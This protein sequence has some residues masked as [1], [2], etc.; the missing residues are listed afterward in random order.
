MKRVWQTPAK[1]LTGFFVAAMYAMPQATISARPG[2]INYI[3]GQTY[4]D[5]Q[6]LSQ[7]GLSK[8]TALYSNQT[9][10]TEK[11][12]A[13][14]LL[15]PGVFLRI[16]ENSEIRMVSPSLTNTQ[17]EVTKGEAIIEVNQLF[18]DSDVQIIEHGSSIT[19]QKPGVYRFM[20]DVPP[21]VSVLDGKAQVFLGEQKVDL[22]KGRQVI[23]ADNLTPQKFDTKKQKQDELY[24]WSD[25]RSEYNAGASYASAKT[26]SQS[27]GFGASSLWGGGAYG[28]GNSFYTPGWFW[29][30]GWNSWAWLP[31]A[32]YA[33]SPF[34]WGFY[35]PGYVLY[36]PVIYRPVRGG[37][38]IPVPYHPGRPVSN[39]PGG[40]IS[41]VPGGV[42]GAI[43]PTAITRNVPANSFRNGAVGPVTRSAPSPAFR[44]APGGMPRSASPG[45]V[46]S[47]G[48]G[49]SMGRGGAAGPSRR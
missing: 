29:N 33:Y 37:G 5:G 10:S 28:Y 20:A 13:E 36:A 9:L 41:T 16:G 7:K 14:V 34:G 21:S 40:P 27:N 30:S 23:L 31:G 19:L 12:K 6:V 26:V 3:E 11:G 18:K 42:R 32:S 38:T 1:I 4:L 24:A 15:T 39:H 2:V 44:S 43:P 45:A 46:R 25:L 49:P 22:K 48:P 47:G 35:S 8:E 17:V